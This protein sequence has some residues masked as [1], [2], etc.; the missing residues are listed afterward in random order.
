MVLNSEQF[1]GAALPGT[2]VKQPH[3]RNTI[4]VIPLEAWEQYLNRCHH[5][6]AVLHANRITLRSIAQRLKRSHPFISFA[7][8]GRYYDLK[9]IQSIEDTIDAMLIEKVLNELTDEETERAP[10]NGV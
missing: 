9:L 7:V 10:V 5:I 3:P 8:G 6:A 1:D 2:G 4:N